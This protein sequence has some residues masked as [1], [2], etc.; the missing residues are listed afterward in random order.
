M[1]KEKLAKKQSELIEYHTANGVIDVRKMVNGTRI[2][3]CTPDEHYELEVGT[4]KHGVVLVASD[5]RFRRRDKVVVTGS[6]DPVTQIFLPQ[7]IGEGLRV[8]LRPEHSPIVR[9]GPV[10]SARILGRKDTYSYDMWR[11]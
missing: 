11:D 2:E 5:R 4:A 8:L 1:M 7:M 3:L 6:V 10:I 9:T